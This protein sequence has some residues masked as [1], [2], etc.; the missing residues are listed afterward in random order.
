MITNLL[1]M[2]YFGCFIES[3]QHYLYIISETLKGLPVF[4]CLLLLFS[5]SFGLLYRCAATDTPGSDDHTGEDDFP[6]MSEFARR[7]FY[8]YSITLGDNSLPEYGKWTASEMLANNPYGSKSMI[9]MGLLIN[10]FQVMFMVVVLMNL[11]IALISEIYE[12]ARERQQMVLYQQKCRMVVDAISHLVYKWGNKDETKL[13][14]VTILSAKETEKESEFQGLTNKIKH[15][16][17][18]SEQKIHSEIKSTQVATTDVKKELVKIKT[19]QATN[20]STMKTEIQTKLEKIKTD[21]TSSIST[22]TTEL[23]QIKTDQATSFS[24]TTDIKT[25]LEKIESDQADNLAIILKKLDAQS[26]VE[27]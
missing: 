19:D 5:E 11:L 6:G 25:K 21:Q 2:C 23:K 27:Q 20:F 17:Q 9:Y 13:A 8:S 4:S 15:L 12:K 14:V 1:K 22:L 26:G 18:K 7:F 10:Y 3:G 24:T 16:I